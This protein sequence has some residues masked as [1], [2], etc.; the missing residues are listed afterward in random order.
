MVQIPAGR[1]AMG[2]D[3]FYPEERPVREV[4]VSELWVDEHPVTNAAFRRFV[5]DT[6]HATVAEP[7]DPAARRPAGHALR[8]TTSHLGFRCVVR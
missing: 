3:D 7:P 1:F 4:E 6:G 5:N 8:S 2:G